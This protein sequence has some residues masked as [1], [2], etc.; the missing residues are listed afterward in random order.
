MNSYCL[1]CKSEVSNN[2]CPQCGQKTSTHRYS[3]KHFLEHDLI[4]GVWHVDKGILFT[5]KE[6]FTRPGHSVR[7]YIEG[8]RVNYFSFVTLI[9]LILTLSA[10]LA[11]YVHVKASDLVPKQ[12]QAIMNSL[13]NFMSAHPKLVL[14]ISIPIYSLF[15]FLWFRKSGINYSE[16]L[17]LNSYRIIP[18][19]VIGLIISAITI[20]YT[21]TSIL[22]VLYL[23]F[24]SLFS[25][26]YSIWFYYQFF[27]A[28]RY[29]K[30]MLL[31]RCA[32][33]PLTYLLLPF[34]IGILFGISKHVF[35]TGIH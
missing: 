20:F 15:S 19:L 35:N 7:E 29:N 16:H 3:I 23:G 32:M 8:K 30:K 11:P 1:N 31:V 6:L 27:S 33:V 4:H 25:F 21:N 5:L 12:S 26:L 24:L 22:A 9:L 18:E 2:Y 28:Y 34:I 17:V 10:M 13:E 14:I